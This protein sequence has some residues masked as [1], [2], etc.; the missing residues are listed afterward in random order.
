MNNDIEVF[1]V[2]ECRLD[3][4]KWYIIGIVNS[5]SPSISSSLKTMRASKNSIEIARKALEKGFD[6]F[7]PKVISGCEVIPSEVTI[8]DNDELTRSKKL[9][10][11]TINDLMSQNILAMNIID[12]MDYLNCYMKLMAA[13][14]FIT[15]SNREDKYFEIIEAAQEN[16]E[17]APLKEDA[18]FEEEQNYIEQKKK[19]EVSQENL[20]TL[21]KYLNAYDKLAKINFTNT[22]LNNIKESIQSAESVQAVNDV[23]KQNED[24]I[25]DFFYTRDVT[26]QNMNA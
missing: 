22:L 18:T 17:P 26:Q 24:K 11:V 19:Y 2:E 23:L 1:L 4:N 12:A 21:E 8:V 16:E 3:N 9:A 14:I 25:K 20:S 5:N 15:D 7:V 6:V 10:L 13:G